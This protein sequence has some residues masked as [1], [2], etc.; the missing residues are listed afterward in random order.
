MKTKEKEERLVEVPESLLLTLVA[1]K[2]KDKVLFPE[3]VESA[4]KYVSQIKE[5]TKLK[6][7]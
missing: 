2:L 3:K 1:D 4:K 5:S 6:F 7:T